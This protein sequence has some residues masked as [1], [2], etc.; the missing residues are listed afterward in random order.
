MKARDGEIQFARRQCLNELLE[1]EMI[2][3]GERC[4]GDE[5]NHRHK[6]EQCN[7]P[8]GQ[9]SGTANSRQHRE[10]VR[11]EGEE[12]K[13][14][15]LEGHGFPNVRN[16]HNAEPGEAGSHNMLNGF[17]HNLTSGFL[18][19]RVKLLKLTSSVFLQAFYNLVCGTRRSRIAQ[20]AL[21]I[22]P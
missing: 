3:Q 19:S 13:L 5:S 7:V 6:C 11:K 12:V 10:M 18:R 20:H 9:N 2:I 14:H 1:E 8:P 17:L 16:E 15:D 4:G 22:P 21:Q